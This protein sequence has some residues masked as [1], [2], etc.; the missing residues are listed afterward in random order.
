MEITVKRTPADK[1][2]PD[3]TDPLLSDI[4]AALARGRAELDSGEGLQ[5]VRLGAVFRSGVRAGQIIE[6]H[7][8][9]QGRSYRAVVTGVEHVAAGGRLVTSLELLRRPE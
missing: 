7:D 6:V 1:P 9:A 3:I 5:T 8:S 2:G 4:R